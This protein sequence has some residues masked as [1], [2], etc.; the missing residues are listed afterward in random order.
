MNTYTRPPAS[1]EEERTLGDLFSDLSQ[2]ASL[3]VRQEVQL[4]KVEMKE[5]ATEASKEVALIVV[6]IFLGNAALLSLAAALIVG[7]SHFMEGW[8][9]ALLVG[10]VLAV[11]AGLLVAQGVQSLRE[12]NALPQQT[13]TTLQEDKE[14]L[15]RQMS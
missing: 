2:K 4:A 13:I 5:K 11:V 10:L 6:G 9:A 8:M 15:K 14:W 1:L 12:M 7:L 3:L